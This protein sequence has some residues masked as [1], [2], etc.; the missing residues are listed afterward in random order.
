VFAGLVNTRLAAFC[1]REN[2]LVDEQGGFRVGRGCV[3]QIFV[4]NEVLAKRKREG[5]KTFLCFID[6][7]KAYDRVWRD[8][9]W[10]ALWKKGVRGR[11]WRVLRSYY[12]EVKSKVRL[13]Q[14][15]T[16]WFSIG[17]GVRQG[18]VLSPTLFALFIDGL[19]LDVKRLGLGV[20][21]GKG[22]LALLLYADDIVLMAESQEDLQKMMR[23][24][25][26]FCD[27]YR[28]E[29][30]ASK[31]KVMVVGTRAVDTL[32][33]V[34]KGEFLEEVEEYKY[35]GVMVEKSGWKKEKAKMIRKANRAAAMV[36]GLAVR[37]GNMTVKGMNNMWTALIR[38]HLEYAAEVLNSNR[39]FKWEEAER[40]MRRVGRKVLKC[41]RTLPNDAIA[42]E[43]GWMSMQGRRKL[44]RLSYWGKI[45]TMDTRRWVRRVYEEG[46]SRLRRDTAA[47]TWCNLTRSWLVELG[48]QEEWNQ[49]ATGAK[50]QEKVREAIMKQEEAEWRR[51]VASSSKLEFFAKWKKEYKM[52]E[53]LSTQDVR[54]RR[55]WTKMRGGCLELR[56]ETGRW[57]RRSVEGRQVKV[58]RA[59]RLCK[60]CGV[61]LEDAEHVMLRCDEYNEERR[62]LKAAGRRAGLTD[63]SAPQE[64]WEWIME[65]DGEEEGMQL[66]A[67][68]M[69]RRA[70]LMQQRGIA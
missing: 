68:I 64:W 26:R 18:C 49:Q 15:E 37:G 4:L 2:I 67:D 51:R 46:R 32:K 52:E 63:A 20:P 38:P 8:G 40:V 55:T 6:M 42:P 58:P 24:V 21:A 45:L 41:G 50:W 9:L 16:E 47:S 53:Y 17:V 7:R 11:M 35:L 54:K 36:W 39:D 10:S 12:A 13:E 48:F 62:G 5:K 3:D 19:A 14:G 60:L 43:L 70:E 44:L 27:R 30:N 22:R 65:G 23:A 69:R 61:E 29:V 66:L 33:I 56:I 59:L 34:W 28:M 25:E 31:T 1:E 57:E